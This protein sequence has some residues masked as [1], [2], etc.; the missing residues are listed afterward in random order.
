MHEYEQLEGSSET[1]EERACNS[2]REARYLFPGLSL[3]LSLPNQMMM[4]EMFWKFFLDISVGQATWIWKENCVAPK[5]R[6]GGH[7]GQE[8][9]DEDGNHQG[10]KSGV[11]AQG[12]HGK[13][14]D[15]KRTRE[16]GNWGRSSE[17]GEWWRV[18]ADGGQVGGHVGPEKSY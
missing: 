15:W 13:E 14:G 18:G 6:T 1:A 4:N 7:A 17:G 10:W 5:W 11:W 2:E 8:P 3:S 16:G 12:G 9:A